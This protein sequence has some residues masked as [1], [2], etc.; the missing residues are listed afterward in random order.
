MPVTTKNC[1]FPSINI[2]FISLKLSS[3]VRG[4]V[5]S[6]ERFGLPYSSPSFLNVGALNGKVRQE[7]EEGKLTSQRSSLHRC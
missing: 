6:D 1:R 3:K 4:K 5:I 7:I 2:K